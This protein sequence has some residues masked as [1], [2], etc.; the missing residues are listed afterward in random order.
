MKKILLLFLMLFLIFIPSIT[1]AG[2][3][4]ALEYN[5]LPDIKDGYIIDST[6]ISKIGFALFE[7]EDSIYCN[8]EPVLISNNRFEVS[9]V[10][11]AGRQQFVITNSLGESVNYTYYIS[12]K[13][14]YVKDFVFEE[15]CNFKDVK[16]YIKT[17]NGVPI[18]YTNKDKKSVEKIERIITSMPQEMLVNLK[19]IRLVPI[20]H[21]S[22]V[23]GV[24]KYNKITLYNLSKY[25]SF[26][27]KNIVIHEIVHTWA[28]DLQKNDLIDYLYSDYQSAVKLDKNYP[29]NYARENAK[30]GKYD[31][32]FA[33]SISF[34]LINQNLFSKNYPARAS[35]I[36][37]LFKKV[38]IIY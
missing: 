14:G 21:E 3:N 6:Y 30:I 25:S 4:I 32:D 29:S 33:E 38:G 5:I 31:E 28:Y 12:N 19:E 1:F 17:I 9:V 23:A 34:F 22:N 37:T 15:L 11:L 16:T 8:N 7:N 35:F 27:L 26:T 24:T 2:N 13:S 20:A 36:T 18:I 10:G